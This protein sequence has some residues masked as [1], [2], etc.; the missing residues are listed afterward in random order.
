VDGADPSS[1]DDLLTCP[2]DPLPRSGG[3]NFQSLGDQR[4]FLNIKGEFTRAFLDDDAILIFYFLSC[5][6]PKFFR[7]SI[8]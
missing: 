7:S 8:A 5:S 3:G 4:Y 6:M 2:F 1:D